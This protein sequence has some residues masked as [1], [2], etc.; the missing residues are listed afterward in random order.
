SPPTRERAEG[1][2]NDGGSAAPVVPTNL[3]E[4]LTSFIGREREQED[5]RRLL[6]G[7]RLLT[8][9]GAG[10]CGKTRLAVHMAGRLLAE[11]PDGVWLV[12]LALIGDA[13]Q[14]AAHQVAAAVAEIVG[15]RDDGGRS[16]LVA[17]VDYFKP[18][19]VLLL[20]DTC[21]HLVDAC[22]ALA[23]T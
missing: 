4:P 12:E 14:G 13:D 9:T 18:R 5:L 16:P 10:G 7:A 1:A 6:A 22:A 21:E 2:A 20:L 23:T 17:L 19:C 8:L 11:Y 3:L 15:L